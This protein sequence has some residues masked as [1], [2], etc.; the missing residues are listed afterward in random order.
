MP[1]IETY[2]WTWRAP[3]D[4]TV[5]ETVDKELQK[6]KGATWQWNKDYTEVTAKG[7]SMVGVVLSMGNN[8][9]WPYPAET[10]RGKFHAIHDQD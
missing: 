8:D 7:D 1:K 10:R 6:A 4:K 2:V 9:K 3:L 5:R